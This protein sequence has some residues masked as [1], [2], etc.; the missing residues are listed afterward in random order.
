MQIK[1]KTPFN[2]KSVL[3]NFDGLNFSK[4]SGVFSIVLSI[5]YSHRGSPRKLLKINRFIN[6]FILIAIFKQAAIIIHLLLFEIFSPS[7]NRKMFR[8]N[9]FG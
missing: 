1:G 3:K 6:I 8:K 2:L 9:N 5:V 7:T 4:H